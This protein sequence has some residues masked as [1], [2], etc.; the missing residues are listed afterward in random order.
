MELIQPQLAQLQPQPPAG[1]DWIHEIKF[2]GYRTLAYID[3]KVTLRTRSGLDWT[4]KYPSIAE[5]LKKLRLKKSVF[6]GEVCYI[7]ESGKS[8]FQKLQNSLKAGHTEN[9]VYFVFDL[10][11]HKGKDLREVPQLKRKEL[12]REVLR[13]APEQIRYAEHFDVNPAKLLSA[14]CSLGLEG[15]ISK[16]VD[17]TYESGRNR[18]WIKS[19]CTKA[20]EFVVAGYTAPKNSRSGFGS[21]VLGAFDHG[22]FIYVGRVGTGFTRQ[23]IE[24]LL[25]KMKPLRQDESPFDVGPNLRTTTWLKPK[26]VAQ[27]NFAEWTAE[28][29]LRHP[30]FQG[31]RDDK[32][33]R[34]VRRET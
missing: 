19:K 25:R 8:D 15:L 24:E 30:S 3:P 21:L 4:E 17:A 33:A 10:L 14:S 18:N 6:D 31:L 23:S 5:A 11:E 32:P 16:R 22:K 12:L 2:D 29:S 26:L 34:Q 1:D 20:Q 28:G 13:R 9:L 7:D 27:V